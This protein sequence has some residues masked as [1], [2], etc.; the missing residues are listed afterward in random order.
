MPTNANAYK[1]TLVKTINTYKGVEINNA[2]A[3]Y[4]QTDIGIIVASWNI[5]ET[6]IISPFT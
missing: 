1:F 4:I 5:N 2:A 3:S 6:R